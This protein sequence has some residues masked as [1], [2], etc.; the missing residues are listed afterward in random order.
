VSMIYRSGGK[1]EKSTTESDKIANSPTGTSELGPLGEL[2]ESSCPAPAGL[3]RR[4]C[5]NNTPL[6]RL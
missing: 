6:F 3:R 4:S 2:E 5:N 1:I